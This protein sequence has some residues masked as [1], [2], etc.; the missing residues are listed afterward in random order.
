MPA[1]VFMEFRDSRILVVDTETTG[2]DPKQ[3]RIVEIGGV[4]Y[5]P[6]V[7]RKALQRY[8]NPGCPI[9]PEATAVH[10]ITDDIVADSPAFAEVAEGIAERFR[11]A[12][13]ILGYNLLDYDL[14]LIEA[15]FARAG[16]PIVIDRSKV[17]DLII[18]ARW[19]MR[20]MRSRKLGDVCAHYEIDL[21][22]AHSAKAD[23][24]AT[25]DLLYHMLD[26]GFLPSDVQKA[27]EVQAKA[28]ELIKAES[29]AW[30]YWLYRDRKFPSVI[31]V[32]AG[33]HVGRPLNAVPKDYIKFILEKM[34]GLHPGAEAAFRAELRERG[35]K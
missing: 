21:T 31:R 5:D 27:V 24:L 19:H 10:R 28:V 1:E 16:M 9:P 4:L 34:E 22:N 26:D 35:A 25:H 17:I 8:I 20:S 32:G 2:I 7:G 11:S 12:D 30:S 18:F 13:V 23:A 14:P 15:E 29:E 6:K 33:K 3:A